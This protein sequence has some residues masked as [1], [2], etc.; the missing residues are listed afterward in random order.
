[1][2]VLQEHENYFWVPTECQQS[3]LSGGTVDVGSRC[4]NVYSDTARWQRWWYVLQEH[5]NY[6]EFLLSVSSQFSVV[7][8]LMS[9]ADVVTYIATLPDDRD[10]GMY[11]SWCQQPM[12]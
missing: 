11:Y 6:F 8:Q 2:Y 9:A 4:C 1:M 12:L 5:E 3:V 7:E 10:D